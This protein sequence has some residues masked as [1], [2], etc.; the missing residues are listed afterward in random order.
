MA[1]AKSK[2]KPHVPK[3]VK[4]PIPK[5]VNPGGPATPGAR[6]ISGKTIA[7]LAAEAREERENGTHRSR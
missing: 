2:L 3:K 4:D 7:E 6:A 5:S 1:T